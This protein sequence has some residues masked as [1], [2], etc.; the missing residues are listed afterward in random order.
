MEASGQVVQRVSG[1]RGGRT[2]HRARQDRQPRPDFDP[3][4]EELQN[5][6]DREQ[7]NNRHTRD[8]IVRRPDDPGQVTGHG[9]RKKADTPGA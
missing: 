8:R 2:D 3:H 9:G 6:R 4:P 1:H 7:N 5:K